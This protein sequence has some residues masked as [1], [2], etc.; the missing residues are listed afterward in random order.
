[1]GGVDP[2]VKLSSLCLWEQMLVCVGPFVLKCV[3]ETVVF[4]SYISSFEFFDN[5]PPAHSCAREKLRREGFLEIKGKMKS[6]W[7]IIVIEE[8]EG[9]NK[10]EGESGR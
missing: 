6:T 7:K 1:M 9:E 10:K 4:D 3:N 8:M 2:V 5:Y